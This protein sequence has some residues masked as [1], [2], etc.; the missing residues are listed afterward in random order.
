MITVKSKDIQEVKS[1][2]NPPTR[3][4]NIGA[5]M[6]YVLGEK[7]KIES[8]KDWKSVQKFWANPNA[9]LQMCLKYEPSKLG[10]EKL[11]VLESYMKAN[12][13]DT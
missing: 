10:K 1:L 6:I 4:I 13:L 7:K 8:C 5:P 11:A 2:A 12:E 9:F 3:I